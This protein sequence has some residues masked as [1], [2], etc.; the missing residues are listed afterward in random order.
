MLLRTLVRTALLGAALLGLAPADAHPQSAPAALTA[1]PRLARP[2][3]VAAPGGTV[4]D[5]LA[6]LAEVTGAPLS[7][8]AALAERRVAAFCPAGEAAGH[9]LGHLAELF[10]AEWV[11]DGGGFR[12]ALTAHTRRT[13]ERL[14]LA[15]AAAAEAA[16][17]QYVRALDE[18]PQALA[19]RAEDDPVRAYLANPDTR[20]GLTLYAALSTR[21]RRDLWTRGRL[22]MPFVA[23]STSQQRAAAGI[24]ADLRAR[25]AHSADLH[26]ASP[27]VRVDVPDADALASGA[28]QFRVRRMAGS[29]LLSLY[30]PGAGMDLAVLPPDAG[31][32]ERTDGSPYG[33]GAS[34]APT[35]VPDGVDVRA[36]GTPVPALERLRALAERTGRCV[37]SDWYTTAPLGRAGEAAAAPD[38]PERLA[39]LD[40]FADR[41]TSRW[42]IDGSALLFRARDWYVRDETEVP[43]SV[44]GRV[45]ADLV[46]EARGPISALLDLAT[47]SPAQMAGISARYSP[48]ADPA[49]LDGLPEL[50]R[51]LS[52]MPPARARRLLGPET[53]GITHADLP[54]RARGLLP[55]F[56]L[57]RDLLTPVP[58]PPAFL[59][60]AAWAPQAG[61]PPNAPAAV[62]VEV[63]WALG[64]NAGMF[65]VFL[66]EHEPGGGSP[67][68]VSP[69]EEG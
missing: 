2:V 38:R 57:A 63:R 61:R 32:S 6:R 53:E 46:D 36:A 10:G 9:V 37:L 23:L 19:R 28:V 51:L 48:L 33:D 67:A 20:A 13:A 22:T 42:W 31:G 68:V 69:A 62:R 59:V 21:Q 8:S 44:Y 14:R 41:M 43:A 16:A 1:D 55:A 66:P 12:L 7:A 29:R 35:D 24:L 58:D 27:D 18:D 11:A 3:R 5:L 49:Q 52:A 15:A 4:R 60:Q 65:V 47:L 50:L 45:A 54:V 26:R 17:A 25:L 64:R 56:A 30:L 40:A 39:A 34:P